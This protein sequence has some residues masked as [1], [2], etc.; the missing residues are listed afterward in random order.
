MIK[1]LQMAG[2]N[3]PSQHDQGSQESQ[4]V[5]RQRDPADQHQLLDDLRAQ[6]TPAMCVVPASAEDQVCPDGGDLPGT[7]T[8]LVL[9]HKVPP[10]VPR[11]LI[12]CVRTPTPES[13][14]ASF[15]QCRRLSSE[16]G[17]G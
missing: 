1:G 9:A 5:Q 7:S 10:H 15:V 12:V 11:A 14:Q 8:R 6:P 2:N 17:D 13:Q 16:K 4:V 3:H